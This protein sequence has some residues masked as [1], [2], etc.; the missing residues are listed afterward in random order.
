MPDQSGQRKPEI[1]LI[2]DRE[3]NNLG[4]QGSPRF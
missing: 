1:L 2:Y 4:L 3:I